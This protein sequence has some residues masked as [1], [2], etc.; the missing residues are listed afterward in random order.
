MKRLGFVC[1]VLGICGAIVF[2]VSA[3]A[4]EFVPA[5]TS[6]NQTQTPPNQTPPPAQQST[7]PVAITVS[8]ASA[9]ASTTVSAPASAAAPADLSLDA[10][11]NTDWGLLFGLQNIFQNSAILQGY[12]GGVGI[13]RN[14]DSTTGLRISVGLTKTSDPAYVQ[15]TTTTTNGMTTM[16]QTFVTPPGSTPTSTV[17]FSLSASLL[18]RLGKGALAAYVGGGLSFDYALAQRSYADNITVM[19]QTTTEDDSSTSLGFGIQGVIGIDWRLAKSISLFAEYGLAITIYSST[20]SSTSTTVAT[21]AGN[22]SV[23][24]T[25]STQNHVFDLG[26]GLLQGATLGVIAH[27]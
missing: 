3:S 7:G 19:N 9:A 15:T 17:G 2:G 21:A 16:T 23:T 11:W 26:T 25:N 10:G 14:F 6:T 12:G 4:Q 1:M 8:P 13:Q 18:K 24:G 27:F 20:S 5:P 22:T